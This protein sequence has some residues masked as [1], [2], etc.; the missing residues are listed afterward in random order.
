[1][2]NQGGQREILPPQR[3]PHVLLNLRLAIE[4]QNREADPRHRGKADGDAKSEDDPKQASSHLLFSEHVTFPP[5]R[6]NNPR[7]RRIIPQLLSQSRNVHINRPRIHPP[8]LDPPHPLKYFISRNCSPPIPR[9]ISQQLHFLL[10]QLIPRPIFKFHLRPSQI[11]H[12][13]RHIHL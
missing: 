3:Q 8:R 10:R 1:M 5:H 2:G 9:Q 7:L 6:Q 12:R 13:S 4:T 11:H